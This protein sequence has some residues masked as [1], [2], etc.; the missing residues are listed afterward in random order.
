MSEEVEVTERPVGSPDGSATAVAPPAG[1][2]NTSA[3]EETRML[4]RALASADMNAL[5]LALYQ[6]TRDE[7]LAELRTE[8]VPVRGGAHM[9]RLIPERHHAMIRSKARGGLARR[10]GM[11][12]GKNTAP[13]SGGR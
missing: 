12:R 11:T 5:R 4:D 3:T 2:A 6:L 1:A 9:V 13:G 10:S 7:S 8:L